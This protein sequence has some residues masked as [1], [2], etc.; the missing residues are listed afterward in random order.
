M[1]V[2]FTGTRDGMTLAQRKTLSRLVA[3]H[4]KGEWV[5]HHGDCKGADAQFHAGAKK[6]GARVVGHPPTDPTHRAFCDFDEARPAAP[7]LTRNQAIVDAADLMFATPRE[8]TEQ[9]RGG[10][11]ATIRMARRARKPIFVVLPDGSVLS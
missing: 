1:H 4:V 8:M 11:W 5:A 6:L 2:G 9:Q 10:T 3:E 7:Y